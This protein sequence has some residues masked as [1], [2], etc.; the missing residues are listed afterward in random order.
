MATDD[1]AENDVTPEAEEDST[2]DYMGLSDEDFLKTESPSS[3]EDK[4]KPEPDNVEID[5]TGS[6]DTT[7]SDATVEDPVVADKTETKDD[8]TVT[9]ETVEVDYKAEFEKVMAP[10]QANGMEMKPK[11]I[12]D[13]TRLMQMG[14]NYHKKMA[15]LKP[16]LKILKLLENNQLLDPEKINFLIDLNSK[17]PAAITKLLKESGM[18]PLDI[19]TKGDTAYTPTSRSVSDTELDLD[20]VL[21]SIKDTPTYNK[22]LTIVTK[23]WDA[24]SRH[25]AANAPNTLAIINQH[26]ADG[27]YEKVMGAVQYERSLGKLQGVSDFDAYK[28][29]GDQLWNQGVIGTSNTQTNTTAP[30][31]TPVKPKTLP[32]TDAKRQAQKKAASPTVNQGKSAATPNF[33]PLTM[34][35]EEIAKF[36]ESRLKAFA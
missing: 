26:V 31:V 10:F 7:K 30:K 9:D 32:V 33:N 21:E 2:S 4:S 17:N 36:D 29:M 5:S 35:D 15:G 27:T 8:T 25:A 20:S 23:D 11:S 6:T 14:A 19:D 3:D 34:S 18:D 28:A 24:S 16:S 1:D 13:V 22:T 12:E